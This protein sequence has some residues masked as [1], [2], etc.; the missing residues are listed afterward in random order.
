MIKKSLLVA[1]FV[2]SLSPIQVRAQTI[3]CTCTDKEG[4]NTATITVPTGTNCSSFVGSGNSSITLTVP[5]EGKTHCSTTTGIK[6][7]CLYT[8]QRVHIASCKTASAPK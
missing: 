4:E 5:V 7:P 6:L 2:A 1:L 3:N 8:L